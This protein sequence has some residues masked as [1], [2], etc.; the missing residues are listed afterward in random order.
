MV[1]WAMS[2]YSCYDC[3]ML[4]MGQNLRL[5]TVMPTARVACPNFA[6]TATTHT[7]TGDHTMV[8]HPKTRNPILSHCAVI[9]IDA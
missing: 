2:L 1:G 9:W 4:G 8:A 6:S 5:L 3:G 7:N